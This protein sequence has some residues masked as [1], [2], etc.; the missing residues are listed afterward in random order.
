MD[1]L[2]PELAAE[3]FVVLR[4]LHYI[5]YAMLQLRN[6]LT[7]M[8][9]GFILTTLS[10]NSYAFQ[11]DQLIRG[12]VTMAFAVLG[13]GIISV[14]I[15]MDR[16]AILSRITNTKA[17]QVGTGF[18]VR[19]IT[20]GGLPLLSVLASHFPTICRFLL[21]WVRPAMESMH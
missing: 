12:M 1:R 2:K 13:V 7:L 18:Y 15:Q 8:S 21:S 14:F 10:L 5:R 20:L 17:G 9:G 3:E 6:L 11:S 16:D 19:V 4:Y